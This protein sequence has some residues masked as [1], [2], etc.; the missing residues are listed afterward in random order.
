MNLM[1]S[2]WFI[3]TR[4]NTISKRSQEHGLVKYFESVSKRTIKAA[5]TEFRNLNSN[6]LMISA[7]SLD[8]FLIAF[9]IYIVGI[10]IGVVVFILECYIKRRFN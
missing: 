1:A 8:E 5:P 4:V 6:S 3:Q 7:G 10:L 9:I 2:Q